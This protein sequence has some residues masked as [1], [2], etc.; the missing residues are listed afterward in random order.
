MEQMPNLDSA[1]RR[2]S[3]DVSCDVAVIYASKRGD[4]V[5]STAMDES[6][7]ATTPPRLWSVD[8][9]AFRGSRLSYTSCSVTTKWD[10]VF[11]RILCT[12]SQKSNKCTF[13]LAHFQI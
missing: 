6:L 9:D 4:D 11:S 7:R 3:R 10:W 2:L 8:A 1:V 5:P 12:N 13:D